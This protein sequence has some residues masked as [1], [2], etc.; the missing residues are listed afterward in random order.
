MWLTLPIGLGGSLA[1]IR[2]F[3]DDLTLVLDYMTLLYPFL[4]PHAFD[5]WIRCF[6]I[7]TIPS[8]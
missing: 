1:L 8:S 3:L 4:C 6:P 2:R 7:V 5:Y